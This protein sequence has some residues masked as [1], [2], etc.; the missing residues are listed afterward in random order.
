MHYLFKESELPCEALESLNLFKN[1][2]VAIDNDNLEAMFAGR[3]SALIAISDVQFNSMRIARLEAKLSLS[4]TDSGEV[5]L[6]VHPVYRSPQPHYLLD[7]QTMGALMDGEKPSHVAELNIDDDRVKHMV[8]EYDAETREFL[9]YDAARV[10]APVMINGE[11]LDVDQREAYRLGKQVTI[12]D[13]TTVQYRVSEP[14][15]ILSN[16]E[17]VILSFQEDT[18]VRQ[19]MLNE[20]KNLQDGFHRQLD[21][22]S[23][24]YQNAL[25]MMLKKDF[26]HLAAAD[27]QVNEQQER[28][29]SR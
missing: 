6:L 17:K 22:N 10:I 3:R 19:V 15:G 11:E 2:K 4:R 20:L 27:L 21:Y 5:E 13:D 28:F 12:Y 1:E 7:Q 25:Q 8:V 16:T 29:R 23:S 18:E 9:A 24:S 14:K 26:P